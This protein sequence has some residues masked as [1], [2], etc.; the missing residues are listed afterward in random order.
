MSP[1]GRRTALAFGIACALASCGGGGGSS[2]VPVIAGTA[3]TPTPTPSASATA[4][5]SPT[6]SYDTAFDFT[7]DRSISLNGA[8]LTAISSSNSGTTTYT[9]IMNQ[10][11]TPAANPLLGYVAAS[12]QASVTLFNLQGQSYSQA[13]ISL[14]ESDRLVYTAPSGFLS[15]AQPGPKLGSFPEALRYTILVVQ[16]EQL[17]D[18]QGNFHST[19]RRF[20]GGSSTQSSDVPRTGA[21]TYRALLTTAALT[22]LKAD[23]YTAQNA[24]FTIDYATGAV[25]GS[26][27][28]TSISTSATLNLTITGQLSASSNRLNGSLTS[29]DGGTGTFTGELFGSQ[30]IEA[31]F[32]FS[33]ARGTEQIVGTVAGIR[34]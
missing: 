7:R 4:T 34:R 23:G 3:P 29:S 20:V 32:A 16:S 30:G 24:T 2:S 21:G 12:Q 31:G 18:V 8:E 6:A 5:P 13:Q 11:Y 9:S 28:A 15:I 1:A 25:R 27:T 26:I 10:V 22:P 14:R 33:L 19:E 17:P